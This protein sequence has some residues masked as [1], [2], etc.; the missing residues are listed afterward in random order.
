MFSVRK[1]RARGRGDEQSEREQ[2]QRHGGPGVGDQGV[3][4]AHAEIPVAC[5]QQVLR[6]GVE[7]LEGFGAVQEQVQEHG[8][9]HQLGRSSRWRRPGFRSV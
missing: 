3:V 5:E 8:V 7:L 6:V 1:L 2:V 9:G 4:P